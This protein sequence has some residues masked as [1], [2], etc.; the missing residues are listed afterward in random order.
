M[1]NLVISIENDTNI[2]RND[3]VKGFTI[4]KP[5]KYDFLLLKINK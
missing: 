1:S 4:I 5:R 2:V 3:T